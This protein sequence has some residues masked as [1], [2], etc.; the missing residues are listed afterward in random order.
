LQ[1][2]FEGM[3]SKRGKKIYNSCCARGRNAKTHIP[4]PEE[5]SEV[6]NKYFVIIALFRLR[7][8]ILN[9][10]KTSTI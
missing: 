1:A 5:K 3:L 9:C 2:A 6:K 10:H 4:L 8:L 7:F